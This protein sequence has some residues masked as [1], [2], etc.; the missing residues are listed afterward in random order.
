MRLFKYLM[1]FR[2]K[3]TFYS[4]FMLVETIQGRNLPYQEIKNIF[5][6]WSNTFGNGTIKKDKKIEFTDEVVFLIRDKNSTILALGC[7]HQIHTNFLWKPYIIQWIGGIVSTVKGNWYGKFL[8]T[9]IRKYIS[10]NNLTAIGFCSK[11][12]TPFYE[13][14]GF[15]IEKW[16]ITRFVT[17]DDMWKIHYTTDTVDDVLYFDG[18]D[19]L[20]KNALLHPKAKVYVPRFW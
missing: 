18:K 13:K 7:L 4:K 5:Q 17:K 15:L 19:H 14:C 2:N 3:F 20:M 16:G 1:N 10:K 6:I 9:E 12:N 8:M 11:H